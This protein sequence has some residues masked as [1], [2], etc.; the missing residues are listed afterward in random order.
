[1]PSPAEHRRVSSLQATTW[2]STT[3]PAPPLRSR[4]PRTSAF[5]APSPGML[6]G[7]SQDPLGSRASRTSGP[8]LFV[9]KTPW[10]PKLPPPAAASPWTSMMEMAAKAF[11]R[12]IRCE[13]SR[14]R[15][16][17]RPGRGLLFVQRIP[18]KGK[19]QN[20]FGIS[21]W[22]KQEL[23]IGARSFLSLV[24]ICAKRNGLQARNQ[25]C[26]RP[27]GQAPLVSRVR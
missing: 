25:R 26:R 8:R 12:H 13:L 4:T 19:T 6:L 7:G 11:F 1:M 3:P 18:L 23:L 14:R 9:L 24:E 16:T 17:P 22:E 20:L 27:H 10:P 2:P 21:P 5:L 15:H